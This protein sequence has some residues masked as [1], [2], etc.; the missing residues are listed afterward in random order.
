MPINVLMCG[1]GEYTT[2]Y[3]AA[4]ASKS[5]KGAGVVALTMFDL[6]EKG[7]VDR[8]AMVGV[9]GKK[10]PQ[11]RD[12]M[13]N[14]IE[15]PYGLNITCDT[16]PS[17]DTVDPLAYVQAASTFGKGDVAIIFTP[18]DT[19]FDIAKCC[20]ERGM[21][22][23]VTK[24][25]VKTLEDHLEL[26]RLSA[27]HSSLIG[28]EVHK[29]YDP[30]YNDAK[31]RLQLLGPLQYMSAYM[32]QPKAQ[33]STFKAWAG[34]SSDISYYLNSHHVDFTE[35]VF[36]GRARPVR[37]TAHSSS[38][39][40]ISL[41][42]PTEDSI[43]L[44]T[45]WENLPSKNVGTCVYTA[46]WIAPPSDVHSQQR[47]FM[48]C[49]EGEVN[50]DQA[51]RGFTCSTDDKGFASCNP[52]FMKYTPKNGKFAGQETYGYKSFSIF[53]DSC[54]SVNAGETTLADY[55]KGEFP[56]VN[57]TMQGTAILE[58]GRMSL[59]ND[60]VSFDIV[61]EGDSMRP[62]EIKKHEYK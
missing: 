21:H 60:N 20:A 47:F 24:P 54:A 34:K 41:G 17:D 45:T 25:I 13:K 14:M 4:G 48:Q 56:S 31:D 50:I 43:T 18:D 55:D 32:S 1:T 27:L 28:V 53:I 23:L 51:H 12:H 38:G 22:V 36:H 8:I 30:L 7:I 46:S 29:R 40:A 15:K 5:D 62:V 16:F 61:Y 2:G 52:L 39:V 57:S 11:I 3:T 59:D 26:S 49:A 19:H 35:W 44:T 9:N 37:V 33:L 10:F 42:V 6:R 58:A